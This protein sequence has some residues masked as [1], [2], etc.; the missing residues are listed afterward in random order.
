[1]KTIEIKLEQ[2][3]PLLHF[4]PAKGATLRATEVKPKLD[5]YLTKKLPKLNAF[6]IPDTN[7]LNYKM[8]IEVTYSDSEK[9]LSLKDKLPMFPKIFSDSDSKLVSLSKKPITIKLLIAGKLEDWIKSDNN[10]LKLAKQIFFFFMKTNFGMRQTKGYGGFMV[11]SICIDG[12]S[13]DSE[14]STWKE[15][16]TEEDCDCWY[17]CDNKALEYVEKFH[18]YL[19]LKIKSVLDEIN[20]NENENEIAR[21]VSPLTAKIC[22]V[23]NGKYGIEIM[24]NEELIEKLEEKHIPSGKLMNFIKDYD[25]CIVE[26]LI[27]V[28]SDGAIKFKKV[29]LNEKKLGDII[30]EIQ[31]SKK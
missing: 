31:E 3:T 18:K 6:K 17:Y 14:V 5:K 27:S 8:Q 12:I 16:W 23:D 15:R 11:S 13:Y 26:A 21:I 1:M 20:E 29:E 4:D 30:K 24:P 10:E 9:L 22:K 25:V 7:A 19:N 2:Q 28:K